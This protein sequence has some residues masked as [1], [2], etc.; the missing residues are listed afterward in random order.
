MQKRK[1][2]KGGEGKKIIPKYNKR[3]TVSADFHLHKFSYILVK[4]IAGAEECSCSVEAEESESSGAPSRREREIP[5]CSLHVNNVKLFPF[6]WTQGKSTIIH[7]DFF[8]EECWSLSHCRALLHCGCFYI[9]CSLLSTIFQ[10]TC[11]LIFFYIF[12]NQRTNA[13][14]FLPWM[15]KHQYTRSAVCTATAFLCAFLYSGQ[16]DKLCCFVVNVH[17]R[18]VQSIT[19]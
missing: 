19:F 14:S 1:E 18:K 12:H 11:A 2:R 6:S 7:A 3:R 10:P 15:R 17:R 8:L 9:D 5:M 16:M 13:F 4:I